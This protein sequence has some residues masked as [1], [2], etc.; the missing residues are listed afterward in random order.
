MIDSPSWVGPS[1]S[2]RV[3]RFDRQATPGSEEGSASSHAVGSGRLDEIAEEY[4]DRLLAGEGPDREAIVASHPEIAQALGR[5]LA[6]IDL[7]FQARPRP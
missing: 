2:S 4:V 1:D 7:I 3:P 5:R 6:L